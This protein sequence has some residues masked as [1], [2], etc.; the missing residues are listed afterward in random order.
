[1]DERDS[2]AR[3]LAGQLVSA[4]ASVGANLEEAADAQSKP[5]FVNKNSIALKECREARYWLRLIAATHD[6]L[7][8]AALVLI[9]ESGELVAIL[10]TIVFRAR[11]STSRGNQPDA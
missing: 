11:K 4:A 10:Q 5:D 2:V 6:H 7:K 1:M 3:R 9:R 8:P